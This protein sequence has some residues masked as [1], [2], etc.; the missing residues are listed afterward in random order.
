VYE[1]QV[2]DNTNFTASESF[3]AYYV[4]LLN[5]TG[6][7]EDSTGKTSYT[8]TADLQPTTRLYW[9]ARCT[10]DGATSPWSTTRS[11]RTKITGYNRPG[12]LYDPILY[13]ETIG[14][15]FGSTTFMGSKGIK[16]N[17]KMSYVKYT[18]AQT[19]SNGEFSVDV[20]GLYP[21]SPGAKSRIFS[22][23]D[24]GSSLYG[25]NY[26]FNVQYRGVNG[27]PDNC[28]SW[29]GMFGGG[30]VKLEPNAN[31]RQ[32]G[33]RIASPT[34]TYHWKATWGMEMRVT[35]YV[36][37]ITAQGAL[38]S[39]VYELAQSAQG[40]TYS[41]N[42]HTAYLGANDGGGPEDGSWAGAVYRNVWI[43][44][45]PRPA[46]LGSAIDPQ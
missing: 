44:N 29:K 43:G 32:A 37:G 25:S 24:G 38:G 19:I 18:L 6:V 45:R 28:I 31:Q 15:R 39:V 13:D 8:P 36:G 10:Q 35:V 30:A 33:V 7:L 26:L 21:N 22:M 23:M 17:D 1:F 14:D 2:A 11:I 20:E 27:N 12:E 40:A 41:P 5:K 16:I 3:S 42:P 9:R 34:Q 46:A 4:V